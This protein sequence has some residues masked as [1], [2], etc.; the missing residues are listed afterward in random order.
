M[1]SLESS[2]QRI[3][4]AEA[5]LKV[6]SKKASD[7]AEKLAKAEESLKKM[8]EYE[9]KVLKLE[10]ELKQKSLSFEKERKELNE[11][12][13]RFVNFIIL[14]KIIIFIIVFIKKS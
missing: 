13:Q 11:K 4:E 10:E 7:V 2:S 5:Q 8:K 3:K 1:T 9:M 14:Y 6:E 12:A